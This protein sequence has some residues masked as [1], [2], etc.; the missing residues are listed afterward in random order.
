MPRFLQRLFRRADP[1]AQAREALLRRVAEMDNALTR[2]ALAA[3]ERL[4]RIS[5]RMEEIVAYFA[6][7]SHPIHYTHANYLGDHTA[8]TLLHGHYMLF[9][10]TRGTDLAPH[11]M[12]HGVWE[13]AYTTV[14]QRMIKPGANVLDIGTNFGV[15]AILGAASGG[16]IHAFDPNPRLC[17]LVRRSAAVNGFT[18][19]LTVHEAAVGDADGEAMVAMSNDWPGGGHMVAPGSQEAGTPCRVLTIDSLFPDPGFRAEVIKIDVEGNEGRAL[20]GMRGLLAR[21]PEVK[22][23]MEFAPAMLASQGVGPERVIEL[24][25]GLGFSFWDIGPDSSLTRLEPAKLAEERDHTIR[26]ILVSRQAP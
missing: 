17:Q 5:R 7:R 9:V 15:Y 23:M 8:L 19:R 2:R 14:F 24:L 11:L 16:R 1:E 21:S 22:I 4:D 26:N 10:D 25:H 20:L 13:T 18:E 6:Q 3:E 12:V